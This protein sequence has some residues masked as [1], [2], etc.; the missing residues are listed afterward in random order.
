MRTGEIAFL[1]DGGPIF[2]A[3]CRHIWHVRQLLGK[4]AQQV[5]RGSG[6]V[7]TEADLL[8]AIPIC[9]LIWR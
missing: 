8:E 6:T 9:I 7:V 3:R 2:S 5:G 1:V 4:E